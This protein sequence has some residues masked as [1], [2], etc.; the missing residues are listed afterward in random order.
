MEKKVGH[1]SFIGGIALALLLG[2][3]SAFDVSGAYTP[4]L[5]SLLV[6]L[7]LIVGFL[8][9]A[10][11]ETKEFLLVATVLII[12]VGMGN[13]GTVLGIVAKGVVEPQSVVV[14][15]K[16]LSGILTQILAFVIPATVVVALK[17]I[18]ALA[19]VQ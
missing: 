19:K 18:A 17:D 5:G 2:I 8:N 10:G 4:W 12:A 1:Y 14:L 15:G 6:V 13:A 3:L 16:L 7:G 9:V 11:K